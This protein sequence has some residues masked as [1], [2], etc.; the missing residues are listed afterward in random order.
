MKVGARPAQTAPATQ[1]ID[2][3][4]Q[5]AGQLRAAGELISAEG[6]L[7]QAVL[8]APQSVA[9]LTNHGLLLSDLGRHGDAVARQRAALALDPDMAPAWINLAL[10]LRQQGDLKGAAEADAQAQLLAP[11]TAHAHVSRALAQRDTGQLPA[12]L[13]GF[14]QALEIDAG[15]PE[16]WI[17]LALTLLDHGDAGA[18]RSAC[19]QALALAPHDRRALANLLMAGQYDSALAAADLRADAA[20]AAA[21]WPALPW[22]PRSRPAGTRLRLGYLSGDFYAHPVGWLLAPVLAAHDRETVEV[23]CFDHQVRDRS[24]DLVHQQL[25]AS[26][27]HWHRLPELDD[28]G[29]AARVRDAGIDV[30]VD[31]SGHTEHGRLGVAALRPAPVQLS[32]LGYF[33]S[34]GLPAMDA[35]VLGEALSPPGAEAYYTEALARVP[36]A[37][38]CYVPPAYA[39]RPA[40]PPS[41]HAGCITFGSFN[42]PA[43]LGDGVV[44]LWAELLQAVPGSRLLLRWKTFADPAFAAHTRGRFAAWGVGPQRVVLRGALPH[45]QMLSSYAEIDVSLDPFPFSGLLTTL[46][47]LWMGV[48]VVTLPWQR[49]VSRQSLAVLQAIGLDQ[50]IATTPRAYLEQAAAMAD[51]VA[52]RSVWRG[53]GAEALRGRIASSA[54]G[55]GAALARHIE[56]HGARLL[57][58]VAGGLTA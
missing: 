41:R 38:F 3:L 21:L 19:L 45:A 20:R 17:N 46:E 4:I 52:T 2:A 36:G 40:A 16:I 57:A 26:A 15:L 14:R 11:D 53:R 7:R 29:L 22:R 9:A 1:D 28:A 42:N 31:L 8:L 55:K 27:E 37:H 39:P 12:A 13:A 50:G 43:K 51:D 25:R 32:W 34:T 47:A 58:A 56:A 35:V 48:P 5:Q 23:H 24:A 33:G 49:P 30:L 44:Q 54:L 18:A 6:L 10:A